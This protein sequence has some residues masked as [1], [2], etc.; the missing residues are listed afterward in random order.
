MTRG[1]HDYPRPLGLDALSASKAKG[2]TRVLRNAAL[3]LSRLVVSELVMNDLLDRILSTYQLMRP[4]DPNRV[5]D[6]RQKITRYIESLASAGQSDTERLV[7]YGLAYL[8]EL[9]EGQD[10]RFTG[11]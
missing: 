5:S 9:H 7:I 11:C 1:R 3:H 4:L 2:L 6:S 8:K 10:P